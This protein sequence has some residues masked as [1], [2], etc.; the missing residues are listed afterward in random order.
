MSWKNLLPRSPVKG[1]RT[2]EGKATFEWAKDQLT[3]YRGSQCPECAHRPLKPVNLIN[4]SDGAPKIDYD[5]VFLQCENCGYSI[6]V[7]ED[8]NQAQQYADLHASTETKYL[9][10]A[11]GMFAGTSLLAIFISNITTF[12][13]GLMLSFILLMYSV[14]ASY[15]HWQIINRRMYEEKPPV[16]DFFKDY[17]RK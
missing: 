2:Q 8:I 16:R 14:Q 1:L 13:G 12:L 17:L 9:Y 3:Q 7:T 11:L 10:A 4:K 15:R 6:D 5:Q